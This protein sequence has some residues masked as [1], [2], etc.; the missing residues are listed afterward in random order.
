MSLVTSCN[1]VFLLRELNDLFNCQ[2]IV[3]CA[4]AIVH[5]HQCLP[6]RLPYDDGPTVYLLRVAL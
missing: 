2:L 5:Q 3:Q 6:N 1:D 4:A